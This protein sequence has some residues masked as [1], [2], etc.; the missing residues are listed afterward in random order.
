MRIAKTTPSVEQFSKPIV[1]LVRA[2]SRPMVSRQFTLNRALQSWIASSENAP[3]GYETNIEPIWFFFLKALFL[4][5][6]WSDWAVLF[7]PH[8][9]EDRH[10]GRREQPNRTAETNSIPCW[11]PGQQ[12]KS[13][14]KDKRVIKTALRRHASSERSLVFQARRLSCF[15]AWF[16][17]HDGKHRQQGKT[18]ESRN[19]WFYWSSQSDDF[20]RGAQISMRRR[21]R[22]NTG[23]RFFGPK[24]NEVKRI[25]RASSLMYASRR[26]FFST[27]RCLRRDTELIQ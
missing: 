18:G 3:S 21:Q 11:Q 4:M 17:G 12:G 2:P 8:T 26:L 27:L 9:R 16:R 7:R 15:V 13:W 23:R 24:Q 10:R 25:G 22:T 20:W 6:V 5:W 1:R 14:T 19:Y